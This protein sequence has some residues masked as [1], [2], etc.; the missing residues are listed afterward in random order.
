MTDES[1]IRQLAEKWLKG[2]ITNDERQIFETWYN[3]HPGNLEWLGDANDEGIKQ[4]MIHAIQSQIA[5]QATTPNFA[6]RRLVIWK[7]IAAAAAIVLFVLAGGYLL[8]F[9]RTRQ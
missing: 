2:T 4:R 7:R 8:F 9:N 3:E 1:T 5:E 6:K